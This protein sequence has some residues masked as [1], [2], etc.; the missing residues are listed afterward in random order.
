MSDSASAPGPFTH[1]NELGEASM[2]DVSAK[3][4]TLRKAVAEGEITFSEQVMEL[5]RDGRT[6]KGDIFTV[7]K[8]AGVM[9]AKRTSDLI[10][11]CHPLP[12]THVEIRFTIQAGE[13]KVIVRSEVHTVAP[14][15][16]EMEALSAASAA[17][18]TI[19]DMTKSSDKKMTIGNLRLV[20]KE[21]GKSGTF[22]NE[23]GDRG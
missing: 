18:L 5:L 20:Y 15:G 9:A 23:A 21:G 22:V 14:T 6:S 16:V 11:L 12:L 17:L 2:V 10:P 19:Y 13:R 8:I 1:L 4:P 3:S 7:A